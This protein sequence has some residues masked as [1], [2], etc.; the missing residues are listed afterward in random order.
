MSYYHYSFD[1]VLEMEYET[2]SMLVQTMYIN[3]ARN[4][5]VN[6]EVVSY[7]KLKDDG[8]KKMHK[9]FYKIAYPQAFKAKTAV[10]MGD[11]AR[12]LNG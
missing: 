2:Y 11:L 9:K 4:T 10:S 6:M 1:E 7:P 8:R 5:L 12:I 3:E